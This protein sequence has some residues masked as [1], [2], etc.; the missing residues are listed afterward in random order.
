M[1]NANGKYKPD[2][3]K[4]VSGLIIDDL[5]TGEAIA[6]NDQEIPESPGIDTGISEVSDAVSAAC[7]FSNDQ[8]EDDIAPKKR[9]SVPPEFQI[10]LA[11]DPTDISRNSERPDDEKESKKYTKIIKPTIDPPEILLDAVDLIRAQFRGA[12]DFEIQPLSEH[13]KLGVERFLDKHLN[14]T[15]ASRV[16]D[17]RQALD[18]YKKISALK[19]TDDEKSRAALSFLKELGLLKYIEEYLGPLYD[20]T[21]KTYYE[22]LGTKKAY[23]GG[24]IATQTMALCAGFDTVADFL[25]NKDNT[26][27]RIVSIGP[28]DGDAIRGIQKARRSIIPLFYV[29]ERIA[30]LGR[31]S[32]GRNINLLDKVIERQTA[33][34]FYFDSDLLGIDITA[35][36]P[37]VL[38]SERN[39][40]AICADACD[41]NL[42]RTYKIGKERDK[43]LR[44]SRKS[45]YIELVE[46]DW[47]QII[48]YMMLDRVRDRIAL[49]KNIKKLAKPGA[50][51]QF[52]LPTNITNTNELGAGI[53]HWDKN[54][55]KRT[56]WMHPDPAWA[57]KYMYD[58][59]FL[60]GFIPRRI[61]M[62]KYASMN[63][64]CLVG[65]ARD[66]RGSTK[67]EREEKR[68]SL[69]EK[70]Y[71]DDRGAIYHL[72]IL[73]NLFEH[74]Y[75]HPDNPDQ[76]IEP[77]FVFSDNDLVMFPEIYDLVI[78]SGDIDKD[79]PTFAD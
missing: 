14:S 42:F 64:E 71:K 73:A 38:W 9:K 74:T 47:D 75:P 68:K 15:T 25:F 3:E 50:Q 77:A 37:E 61:S 51:F 34:A 43:Q 60:N 35:I 24:R 8:S 54:R 46:N 4:D 12:E 17:V 31:L 49:Y 29:R 57:I 22:L 16:N 76:Q 32:K 6:D 1:G 78:F 67:E 70:F 10:K 19:Q 41:E 79:S 11:E 53:V 36:Y 62:Q 40:Q 5:K 48:A 2:L 28:G 52:S 72:Q 26:P 55:D 21:T 18:M 56:L 39:M 33:P 27:R 65:C 63:P 66:L 20:S 59:L 58:D 7:D 30:I 23:Y 13:S 44:D 45:R 69:E